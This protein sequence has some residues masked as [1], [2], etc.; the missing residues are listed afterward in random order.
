MSVSSFS[1]SLHF[2]KTYLLAILWSVLWALLL[3]VYF[4][5]SLQSRPSWRSKSFDSPLPPP[6]S[7]SSPWYRLRTDIVSSKFRLYF[8]LSH[9]IVIIKSFWH[10]LRYCFYVFVLVFYMDLFLFFPTR[11]SIPR[12][13]NCYISS[14]LSWHQAECYTPGHSQGTTTFIYTKL[15]NPFTSVWYR[16]VHSVNV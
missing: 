8:P 1:L 12:G 13:G 11:F 15:R 6:Q 7:L 14:H 2:S 5:L 10:L 3:H 4:T 16:T 9:L